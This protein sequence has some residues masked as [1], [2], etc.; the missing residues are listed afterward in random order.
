[1]EMMVTCWLHVVN[2]DL[3]AR[4]SKI[5]EEKEKT[6]ALLKELYPKSKYT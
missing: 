6:R 3:S 2:E 5:K 1:M 4:L